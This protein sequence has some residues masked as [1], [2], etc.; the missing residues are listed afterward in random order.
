MPEKTASNL[1]LFSH[2]IHIRL[3][4]HSHGRY[5]MSMQ[6]LLHLNIYVYSNRTKRLYAGDYNLYARSSLL[7]KILHLT[8]WQGFGCQN[9][10]Q[11]I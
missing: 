1:F 2:A 6:A 9:H 4:L 10:Q 3:I 7:C 8:D 5:R 11:Q